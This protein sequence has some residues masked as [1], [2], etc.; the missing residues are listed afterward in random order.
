ML[1]LTTEKENRPRSRG[2]LSLRS[3][4]DG[5]L[6]RLFSLGAALADEDRIDRAASPGKM[7]SERAD[8]C[9]VHR[10]FDA[11]WMIVDRSL[12]AAT[13]ASGSLGAH[14]S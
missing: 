12:Y 14:F 10:S 6:R 1:P 2:A 8:R 3:R 9:E 5:Q 11:G 13:G 7:E 4:G